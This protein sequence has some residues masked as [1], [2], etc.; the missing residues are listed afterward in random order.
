MKEEVNI[1]KIGGNVIDNEATLNAFLD[2]FAA[3]EGRKLLVHGGGKVATELGEKMGIETKMVEGRRIT[4]LES[5]KLA[6]MVYGGLVNKSVVAKLQA[7]GCN[8][9]GLTGADGN[10][11]E[12]EIRPVKDIDYGYVGDIKKVNTSFLIELLDSDV[13]PVLAPLTH[14]KEG[15][16]L[17]TNADT[18]AAEVAAAL[19]KV[20]ETQLSYCFELKGVLRDIDDKNSVIEEMAHS[21]YMELRNQGIISRGMIPKLDN[22]YNAINSGVGCIRICHAGDIKSIINNKA[23]KGTL[24][25]Y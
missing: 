17:N 1:V 11:I 24:L 10:L 4:D 13:V 16:M 9:I 2:D 20:Y 6:M 25:Y 15:V 19:G 8:A 14:N 21:D 23:K 12:A 22:C 7:K 5:L 3:L 18:I